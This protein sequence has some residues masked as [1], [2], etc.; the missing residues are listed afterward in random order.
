M[1]LEDRFIAT[2]LMFIQAKIYIKYSKKKMDFKNT[3]KKIVGGIARD[4]RR[5]SDGRLQ[6]LKSQVAT[7]RLSNLKRGREHDWNQEQHRDP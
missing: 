3:G 5:D 2:S 7:A 6:F 4:S 1:N